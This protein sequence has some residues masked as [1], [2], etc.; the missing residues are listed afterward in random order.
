MRLLST[1]LLLALGL[2]AAS[3]GS[4]AE[5]SAA[6]DS[7]AAARDDSVGRARQDSINR[8]QPGYIVDSILPIEEQLRRFRLDL[9][10]VSSLAGGLPSREALV[11]AFVRAVE[12]RDTTALVRLAVSAAEFAWLVYPSSDYTK[13]PLQQAPQ[14]VW[15]LA[16]SESDQGLR[17]LLARHGG[18]PLG[19]HF[20]RCADTPA[21][22]G[23]NRL[24]SGCVVVLGDSAAPPIRLFGT[25]LERDGRWKVLSFANQY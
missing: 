12:Q 9:P 13:P 14:I 6:G 24:W 18:A 15:F 5:E 11:L 3:C 2:S 7:I 17:R 22:Q 4:A 23:R 16:S 20:H 21:V 8:A 10:R 25:L 19:F 1:L